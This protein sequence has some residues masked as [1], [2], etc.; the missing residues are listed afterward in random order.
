[1]PLLPSR[2]KA[3]LKRDAGYCLNKLFIK[4][5]LVHFVV[6]G[7]LPLLGSVFSVHCAMLE[8]DAGYSLNKLFIKSFLVHFVVAGTLPLLGTVQFSREKLDTI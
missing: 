6:A 4:I 5:F 2:P 1:M 7:T 8:R 3:M